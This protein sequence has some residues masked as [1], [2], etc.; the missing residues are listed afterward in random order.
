MELFV[1]WFLTVV[2]LNTEVKE[3]QTTVEAHNATVK[4]LQTTVEAHNNTIIKLAAK[5]SSNYANLKYEVDQADRRLKAVEETIS[6]MQLE[7]VD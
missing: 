6:E 2:T 1:I 3:L 5:T 4:E 7:H